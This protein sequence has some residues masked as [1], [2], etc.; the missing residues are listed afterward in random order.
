MA[1]CSVGT[2]CGAVMQ[3]IGGA[4]RRFKYATELPEALVVESPLG[5][6]P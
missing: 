6:R 2:S 5:H 4:R 1:M 3:E